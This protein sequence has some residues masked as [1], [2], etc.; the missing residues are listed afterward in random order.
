MKICGYCNNAYNDAEPKC[1]VCGSTLLKHNKNSD[2]AESELKRIKDE[3]KR[4][5]KIRS[6]IIGIGASVIVLAIVIAIISIGSYATDPQRAISKESNDLF[7][8]AEQQI[9]AGEYDDAIDILNRISPEWDNY[10]KVEALRTK[11]VQAKLTATANQYQASGDYESVIAFISENVSDFNSNP[12]I[13]K[14]YDDSVAKYKQAVLSKADDY[15]NAGD[16][17]S[18]AS[19]ITTAI[20]IVGDD[21]DLISKLDAINRSE[22]YSTVLDYKNNGEYALAITYVNEHMDIVGTDSDILLILSECENEYREGVI[23]EATNAY[24]G[25]GYQAAL[26]KINA[27]LAVM[28]NDPELMS[29]QSAYLA[30]EPI[31]LFSLEPYTYTGYPSEGTGGVDTLGN[32]YDHFWE[33]LA[34][35]HNNSWDSSNAGGSTIIYDIGGQYNIL[36]GT[37]FVDENS[38]GDDEISSVRIF[39]D[40][41]LLYENTNITCNTKPITVT[42]DITNVFDLKIEL[43]TC[44]RFGMSPHSLSAN[45]GDITL[46]KTR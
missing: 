24:Q 43:I 46:Q 15:I 38:K 7:S 8:Q 16:Y 1:P 26:S 33:D 6:I 5:R 42:L 30:C 21:S 10:D 28:P 4:K 19:V 44:G 23:E 27:G 32:V 25:N 39:G 3:I 11:A 14:I 41:T 9:D 20:R 35:L 31:S 2:P 13:K 45:L 34:W 12:E 22:I 18:A 37:V 17:D 36:S 40:G 29:E